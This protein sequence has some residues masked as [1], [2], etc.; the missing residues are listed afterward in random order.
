MRKGSRKG[1]GYTHPHSASLLFLQIQPNSDHVKE[2][3]RNAVRNYLEDRTENS[4][5]VAALMNVLT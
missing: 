2:P 4:I 3:E 1:V 5:A